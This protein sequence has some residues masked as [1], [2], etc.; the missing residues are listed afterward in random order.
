MYPPFRKL[1]NINLKNKM[2]EK[3]HA[4]AKYR[5]QLLIILRRKRQNAATNFLSQLWITSTDFIPIT[6]PPILR[7]EALHSVNRSKG[8]VF[9]QFVGIYRLQANFNVHLS[10]SKLLH[11]DKNVPTVNC[12]IA[13]YNKA[14]SKF[15]IV[16]LSIRHAMIRSHH[17]HYIY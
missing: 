5:Q 3:H 10:I 4:F 7:N 17:R 15:S 13:L 9:E 11:R 16:Q 14:D 8:N 1:E 12:Q 2:K 6:N